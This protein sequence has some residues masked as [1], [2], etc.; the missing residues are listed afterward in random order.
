M[1]NNRK[2]VQFHE[3]ELDDRILKVR[4]EAEFCT[5]VFVKILFMQAI[6][7]LGWLQPTLIQE[8]AIPLLLE[9][10]DVV[11]RARTGSG[12]TAAFALPLIQKILNS[13]MNASEQCVSAVIL[14]PSKELCQQTRKALDEM[15]EKCGKVIR[16][17]DLS[18]SDAVTQRHLLA[19]RPD[20]VISTPAKI[21]VH[22]QSG[23]MDMKKL[24]SLIVDEADLIFSF[25]F[26]KDFKK[27]V[28][29]LPPVYQVSSVVMFTVCTL[30]FSISWH[31]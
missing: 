16:V 31:F 4:S 28:D 21:L 13:K 18:N 30:K 10:K 7:K 25:G 1:A 24:E 29:Y 8:A 9:G 14:S 19:E 23:A 5:K 2:L 3:M 17:V 22:L 15:T 12:K 6:S 11:V 26:E 20:I 27:L